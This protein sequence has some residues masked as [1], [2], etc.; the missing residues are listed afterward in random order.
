MAPRARLPFAK[1]QFPILNA[2]CSLNRDQRKHIIQNAKCDLL[3]CICE[4]ALNILRGNVPISEAEKK[5]LKKHANLLRKIAEKRGTWKSKKSLIKKDLTFLP[6]LLKPIL[7]FFK[8]S[9]I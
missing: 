6:N 4:C 7:S 2:L 8:D 1:K 3:K 9:I 5:K